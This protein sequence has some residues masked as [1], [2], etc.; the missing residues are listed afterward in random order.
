VS[1]PGRA[2]NRRTPYAVAAAGVHGVD[3]RIHVDDVGLATR[4]HVAL[5][6]A[7]LGDGDNLT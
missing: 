3:E 7:L 6:R 5:C 4:F 1:R 2:G